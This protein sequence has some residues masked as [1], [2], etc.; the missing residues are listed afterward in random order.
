M[1]HRKPPPYVDHLLDTF[2]PQ[3]LIWGSRLA[4][5]HIGQQL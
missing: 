1:D 3:R 2:G 5:V 4:G